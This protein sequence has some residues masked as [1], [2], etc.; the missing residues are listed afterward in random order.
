MRRLVPLVVMAGALFLVI[1]CAS[2]PPQKPAEPAP[3]QPK[4]QA[5]VAAPEAE[6]AQAKDLKQ[7]VDTWGLGDYAPEEYAAANKDLQAGEDTY[8]KDN[9]SSKKSLDSAITE[10]NAVITDGGGKFLAKGQSDA[11][12]SKKAADDLK[13]SVAVK[14]DYARADDT[15]QQALKEKG[16]MDIGNAGKDFASARDQFDAVAKTAQEKK[17]AALQAMQSA[18]EG[19]SA[20]QQKADDSEKSLKD[21][22]FSVPAGQ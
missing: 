6:L 18:Q 2:T 15:Y 3:E 21:E 10:Y 14:D 1:S 9:A 20:S 4:P 11:E 12:A 8:G 13:A 17:D 16:A 22:G 19:Q 7:K 5:A